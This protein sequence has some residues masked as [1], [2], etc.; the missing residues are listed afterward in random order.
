MNQSTSNND[1][2]PNCPIAPSTRGWSTRLAPDLMFNARAVRARAG[3]LNIIIGITIA[4]VLARPDLDISLFV[5][6]LLLFDMLVAVCFGLTP[7]S[8]AGMIGTA[9]TSGYDPVPTPHLPKRFAW[10]MGAVLA[11]TCL[12]L[13]LMH[14]DEAWIAGTYALFFLLTWL[15]A[16]L[17]FCVGCWIYSRLFDCRACRAG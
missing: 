17:G 5:S 12:V 13:R 8:P 3:V 2:A 14:A 9:L 16:T 15:D 4:L 6:S 7:L 11:A 1:P 10:S